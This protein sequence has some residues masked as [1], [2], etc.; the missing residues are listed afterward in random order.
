MQ[1]PNMQ[2]SP[3]LQPHIAQTFT[4]AKNSFVSDAV[5]EAPVKG[6]GRRCLLVKAPINF[7][8]FDAW[9]V[10]RS[11]DKNFPIVTLTFALLGYILMA[12]LTSSFF[13]MCYDLHWP[14]LLLFTYVVLQSVSL[15]L[16][17]VART[18]VLSAGASCL[19]PSPLPCPLLWDASRDN[20]VHLPSRIWVIKSRIATFSVLVS[21]K[22]DI[23]SGI[24]LDP[25]TLVCSL[26]VMGCAWVFLL[27]DLALESNV[28]SLV[29]F[30]CCCMNRCCY[31][32][33]ISKKFFLLIW[34]IYLKI[35]VS[36]LSS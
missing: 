5:V 4:S 8:R 21:D 10:M 30:I 13:C 2:T 9:K 22:R 1:F 20:R 27:S 25:C 29:L 34:I 23:I 24:S 15:S 16:Q 36:F 12:T 33:S 28:L 6:F 7:S 35:A 26:V 32:E 18:P 3:L 11:R 17:M 19:R 31:I 14:A